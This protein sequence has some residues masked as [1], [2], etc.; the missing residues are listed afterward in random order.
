MRKWLSIIVAVVTIAALA[1]VGCGGDD[2]KATDDGGG[3]AAA[4]LTAKQIVK[5]SSTTMEGVNSATMGLDM[6]LGVTGDASKVTDEQMKALLSSPITVAMDGKVGNDPQK[7]DVT[8]TAELMSKKYDVGLRM[9]DKVVYVQWDGTWYSISEDMV[10]GMTGSTA[11][12]S[13][14]EE[15]KLTDLIKQLGIDP[16]TWASNYTIEGEE[17]VAGVTTYHISEAIDIEKVATDMSTLLGSASGLGSIL[18]STAEGADPEDLQKSVEMLKT[19]VKDVQVDYWIGKD[20]FYMYKTTASAKIDFMALPEADRQGAEGLE[21]MDFSMEFTMADFN[22][23]FTV[24]VPSGA[25]SFE[26]LMN[27]LMQ[28]GGLS[29]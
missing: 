3:G 15:A 19:A 24:E 20:D 7:L 21:S 28:S 17:D 1:A 10:Q 6:T 22:K 12:P 14:A 25:K 9:A 27:T 23:D 11:S 2:K 26:E 16:N 18:G 13:A 5:K 8:L 4:E 29:L